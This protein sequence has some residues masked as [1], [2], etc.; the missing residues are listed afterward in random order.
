MW[1]SLPFHWIRVQ[2][3]R[4]CALL[5][6]VVLA[7]CASAPVQEMSDA[8]QAIQAAEAAGA[9][10]RVPEDYARAREF[11]RSAEDALRRRNYELAREEARQA[12]A[13]A[14]RARSRAL[15]PEEDAGSR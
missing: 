2:R 10:A 8:R 12:K 7:A 3:G 9:P 11:L 5:F 6:S 13:A 4:L 15:A 1:L 14:M